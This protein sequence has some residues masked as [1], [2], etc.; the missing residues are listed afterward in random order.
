M[1]FDIG[2]PPAAPT[3]VVVTS[4]FGQ[5]IE[6]SKMEYSSVS[7]AAS[8]AIVVELVVDGLFAG[9]ELSIMQNWNT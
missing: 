4:N 2:C 3:S 9:V 6:I 1:A 8:S 7:K 5:S